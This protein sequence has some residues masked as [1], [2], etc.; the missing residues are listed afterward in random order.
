MFSPA[1]GPELPPPAAP[2]GIPPS[3]PEQLD[4]LAVRA[5]RLVV[6]VE[7]ALNRPVGAELNDA[8]CAL[9]A[10][11]ISAQAQLRQLQDICRYMAQT[12]WAGYRPLAQ[13]LH[14]AATELAQTLAPI[15]DQPR[16]V[17]PPRLVA[18]A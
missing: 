12:E 17:Q 8:R 15:V 9:I 1:D 2:G 10:T 5:E 16:V 18:S 13:G 11:F 6:D 7:R 4:E 14:E 3:E